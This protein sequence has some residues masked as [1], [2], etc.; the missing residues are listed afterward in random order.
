MARRGGTAGE[1]REAL[2]R[3][4]VPE[5][6]QS[7]D[8]A[9]YL[10]NVGRSASYGLS[11][12]LAAPAIIGTR[13]LTGGAPLSLKEASS[14]AQESYQ[15]TEAEHPRAAAAGKITGALTSGTHF[16]RAATAPT[17]MLRVLRGAEAGTLQG[18]VSAYNEDKSPIAGAAIG[19][20]F[21]AAGSAV[22][23]VISKAAQAARGMFNRMGAE[24]VIE[25]LQPY[26]NEQKQF[27]AIA[28]ETLKKNKLD[29]S[30]LSDNQLVNIGARIN[31]NPEGWMNDMADTEMKSLY[32]GTPIADKS[33]LNKP[34][35]WGGSP[36]SARTDSAKV[37]SRT[38]V[39][40]EKPVEALLGTE[41][42]LEGY[43]RDAEQLG[44]GAEHQQMWRDTFPRTLAGYSG[45]MPNLGE[46]LWTA[47]KQA[48]KETFREAAMGAPAAAV[49]SLFGPTGAAIGAAPFAA[50]ATEKVARSVAPV[51]KIAAV[52]KA[53]P[54]NR[55]LSTVE[56]TP[57]AT[58]QA[59]QFGAASTGQVLQDEDGPWND[60]GPSSPSFAP[61]T[62]DD[63][64]WNDK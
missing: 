44:L 40:E 16:A 51:V 28:V 19:A 58:R 62:E 6:D 57:V 64:P 11:R 1:R 3:G 7:P 31:R 52:K 45:A 53:V 18:G 38:L 4:P 49:G 9:A 14:L 25:T 36:T 24:Q 63:G 21:G 27:R 46:A 10:E 39:N 32:L 54:I 22:G 12:Y 8:F 61:P 33:V 42:K 2:A 50:R 20:A 37:F 34:Y 56:K 5:G 35:G 41:A 15:Q 55:V 29:P 13:A 30:T 17:A 47:T 60:A 23:D 26:I 59:T 48:G 43:A